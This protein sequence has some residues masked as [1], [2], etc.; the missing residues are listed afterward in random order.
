MD[1]LAIFQNRKIVQTTVGFPVEETIETM[2]S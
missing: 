2:H 1:N